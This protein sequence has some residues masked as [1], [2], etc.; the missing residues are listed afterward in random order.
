[1]KIFLVF[2]N[3]FLKKYLIKYSVEALFFEIKQDFLKINTLNRIK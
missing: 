3:F 1:M 2:S